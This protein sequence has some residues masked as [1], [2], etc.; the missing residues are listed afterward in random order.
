M[1]DFTVKLNL[2][3]VFL[4]YFF[5]LIYFIKLIKKQ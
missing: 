2:I 4:N 5:F 1:D 3:N